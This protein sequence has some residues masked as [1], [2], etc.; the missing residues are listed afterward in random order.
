MY[1]GFF[2]VSFLFNQTYFVNKKRHKKPSILVKLKCCRRTCMF[3]CVLLKGLQ[4]L[5]WTEKLTD[6]VKSLFVWFAFCLYISLSVI[7]EL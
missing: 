4:K 2:G 3:E 1:G 5:V 6:Q 7:D